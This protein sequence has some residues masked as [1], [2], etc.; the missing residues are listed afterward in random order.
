[1]AANDDDGFS[2]IDQQLKPS[3]STIIYNDSDLLMVSPPPPPNFVVSTRH[4]TPMSTN[5]SMRK[6]T[7]TKTTTASSFVSPSTFDNSNNLMMMKSP[8]PPPNSEYIRDTIQRIG[9]TLDNEIEEVMEIFLHGE[10]EAS[11]IGKTQKHPGGWFDDTDDDDDDFS[12]EDSLSSV[13]LRRRIIVDENVDDE[14]GVD[15]PRLEKE[16]TADEND[17][18]NFSRLNLHDEED[19]SF[20]KKDN[21]NESNYVDE[22]DEGSN[23]VLDASLRDGEEVSINSFSSSTASSNNSDSKSVT[24]FDSCGCWELDEV[25]RDLILPS[26]TANSTVKWPKVRLPL[27]LYNKLFQHQRI[28]VQWM[29]SLHRNRIKG[30]ILADDMGMG[31]TLSTLA[32]LGSLMRAK[33]IYNAIVV[34]PKSVV[35]SWEREANLIIK[36]ICV[37]KTTVYAV[38][39]DMKC[40]KR[41]RIFT[42]AFCS[43]AESPRLIV[44]TYVRVRN[45]VAFQ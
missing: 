2:E 1:M 4:H 34:C 22:V 38:T 25:G 15:E 6:S 30:G 26:D 12:V 7:T 40:E 24:C 8:P 45:E 19:A 16:E 43:S 21:D 20:D 36:N 28:G 5:T 14:S 39:S 42:E 3:S 29:A 35:R 11:S 33:T 18:L 9:Q 23:D 27:S 44:T 10:T 41:K 32:Y 37:P 17:I 13:N 31:K